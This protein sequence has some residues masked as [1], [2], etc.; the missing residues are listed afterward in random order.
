MYY[1]AH[2][3]GLSNRYRSKI[4]P[5]AVFYCRQS[6]EKYFYNKFKKILAKGLFYCYKDSAIS[7]YEVSIANQ[8]K[9]PP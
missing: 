9:K 3:P 4:M 2:A 5:T 6:S 8:S 1:W 7:I